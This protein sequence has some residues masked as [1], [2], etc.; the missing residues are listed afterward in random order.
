MDS[1]V[2]I[3]VAI[4]VIVAALLL[5]FVK[6]VQI[7]SLMDE[8]NQMLKKILN[9][10]HGHEESEEKTKPGWNRQK[11]IIHQIY[12]EKTQEESS[13]PSDNFN[14]NAKV[15]YLSEEY[16]APQLKSQSTFVDH[17]LMD[18]QCECI[19]L[20]FADG[21]KGRIYHHLLE[22]HFFFQ[23]N[24]RL[25]AS[26]YRYDNFYH[27]VNAFHSYETTGRIQRTGYTGIFS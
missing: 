7:V 16:I 17:S 27:C 1:L 9:G 5:L 3:F 10:I 19:Q 6:L 14:K 2:S 25:N 11:N 26:Y 23:R 13:F 24:S 22:N 15:R 12:P 21:V 20:E 4:S 8:Q 18:G